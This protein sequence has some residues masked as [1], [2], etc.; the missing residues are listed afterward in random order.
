MMLLRGGR[1]ATHEDN[2]SVDAYQ[3]EQLQWTF[4]QQLSS[5]LSRPTTPGCTRCKALGVRE[6]RGDEISKGMGRVYSNFICFGY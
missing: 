6:H 4:G 2:C 1:M 3:Q 5:R